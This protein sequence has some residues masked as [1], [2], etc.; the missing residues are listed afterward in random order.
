MS[1]SSGTRVGGVGA[2]TDE[3]RV[4]HGV[5]LHQVRAVCWVGGCSVGDGWGVLLCRCRGE[6]GERAQG[7]ARLHNPFW[8]RALRIEETP[9][10]PG[11]HDDVYPESLENWRRPSIPAT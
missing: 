4:Y 1:V 7:M 5:V 6:V 8:H 9:I 11:W 3:Y 10:F 2:R